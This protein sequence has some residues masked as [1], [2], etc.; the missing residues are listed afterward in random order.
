MSETVEH[1]EHNPG[2]YERLSVA[3]SAEETNAS[4]KA[5]FAEVGELR[6]KHGIPDVVCVVAANVKYE[7]GPGSA[8]TWAQFGDSQKAE[9]LL[10]YAFGQAQAER[11]EF[12]NRL[13][14]GKK[15]KDA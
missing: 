3:R 6:E 9:P 7:G 13:L 15:A 5:F 1:I 11:R 12:V 8:M 10:A 2:R 4:L 14:S